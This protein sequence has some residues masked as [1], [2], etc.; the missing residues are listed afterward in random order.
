MQIYNNNII[1]QENIFIFDFALQFGLWLYAG[2]K[3]LR[4]VW[5]KF[6][7]NMHGLI[8]TSFYHMD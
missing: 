4:A 8:Y 5:D 3:K 6:R 1:N 7:L 2:N